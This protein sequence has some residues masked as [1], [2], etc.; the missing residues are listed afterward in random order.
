MTVRVANAEDALPFPEETFDIVVC[1]DVLEHLEHPA[2]ALE[3]IMK[4]LKRG[5]VLYINT[6]NLNFIRKKV[7]HHADKKEHHVSLF[8]RN[9][10][11]NL[12]QR[13]GFRIVQHWTFVTFTVFFFAQ[14]KSN[15]GTESAFIC[16]K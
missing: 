12:L 13:I 6:P 11:L 7:F 9:D 5:G 3:N 4:G 10:M 14:F 15:T 2:K 8:S 1:N 16:M